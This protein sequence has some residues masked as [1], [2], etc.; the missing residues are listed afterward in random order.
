MTYALTPAQAAAHIR[1]HLFAFAPAVIGH[2]PGPGWGDDLTFMPSKDQREAN[3]Q[4]IRDEMVKAVKRHGTVAV[5]DD[6]FTWVFES[7]FIGVMRSDELETFDLGEDMTDDTR[8]LL[9]FLWLRGMMESKEIEMT[10]R[11]AVIKTLIDIQVNG[12]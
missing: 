8:T 5:L 10:V 2:V 3:W 7:L 9:T 1:H 4:V 12:C 6:P 11:S